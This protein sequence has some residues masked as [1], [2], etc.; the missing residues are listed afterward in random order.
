MDRCSEK[1][2]RPCSPQSVV[3]NQG[4]GVFEVY[5]NGGCRAKW[6]IQDR[7]GPYSN[8]IFS[9][10]KPCRRLVIVEMA[11]CWAVRKIPSAMAAPCS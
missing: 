10:P 8:S 11:F 2:S 4:N 5:F 1:T 9:N 3:T 7:G 6:R